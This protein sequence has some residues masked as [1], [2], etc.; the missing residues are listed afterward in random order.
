[1]SILN[2]IGIVIIGR[3]EGRRIEKCV[4]SVLDS[5]A[6]FIYVDSNS[7]DNSVEIVKRTGANILELDKS[8]PMS[9]ARARNAGYKWLIKN[10]HG[11]K[12]VH[13]IDGDCELNKNWPK[14]ACEK[15]DN[16]NDI[17]VVCG[18]LREK[19]IS[20]SIYTKLSDIGWYI[21]PGETYSCGGIAT[22]RV[23]TF[24][25]LNGFDESLI[26]GEEPEFYLR[27]RKMGQIM[28]CLDENMGTH[29]SAMTSYSQ[30]WT[31]SFRTGFAY[32]N[33]ARWGK[34]EQERRSFIFWGAILPFVLV[35]LMIIKPPL[36]ILLLGIYPLQV[37]R[38]FWKLKIPY[39]DADRLIY[40]CFC[41]LDKFPEF[42]GYVKYHHGR[43]TGRSQ[44]IIEYKS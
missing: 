12:Y 15:L 11:L 39:S 36:A 5:G 18:R 13:F 8:A 7:S 10:V 1:M 3:N 32:A 25:K 24:T 4:R 9:A 21:R 23:S 19:N 35:I 30:W 40:A 22:I 44:N 6:A 38:I 28:F 34:W 37:I 2:N 26:A 43:I 29:D 14:L 33:A 41:V 42:C 31:R 16:E 27:V 17:A 20:K